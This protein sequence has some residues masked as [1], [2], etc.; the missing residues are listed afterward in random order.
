MI[1]ALHYLF[2]SD[3]N[4]GLASL[5]V[6]S[7]TS[8]LLR[9]PPGFTFLSS[10]FSPF[11]CFGFKIDIGRGNVQEFSFYNLLLL[12]AHATFNDNFTSIFVKKKLF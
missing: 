10:F 12:Y 2:I 11:Q 1:A 3:V 8:V 9:T 7:K 4:V 6:Y 5:A